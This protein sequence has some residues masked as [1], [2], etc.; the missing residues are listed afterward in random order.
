MGSAFIV[1]KILLPY[2]VFAEKKDVK[3]MVVETRQGSFGFWPNRLDC[4]AA[5]VPGILTY[6]TESE[7]EVYVAV[8]EGVVVKTGGEVFVS[9]RHAIGGKELGKLREAVEHEF[10]NLEER[11]KNVRSVLAKL[12]SGFIRQFQKFRKE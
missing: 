12:E 6:E 7:G 2:G 4:T 8:D 9:V 5:L 1:L 10:L 11:E 3:R